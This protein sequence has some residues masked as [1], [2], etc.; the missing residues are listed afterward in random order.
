M[1]LLPRPRP[2]VHLAIMEML[3]IPVERAIVAGHRLNDEIVRLPE[4]LHHAD[5]ILVGC[6][7][8]VRHALDEPHIEA[9]TRDDVDRRKLLRLPQRIGPVSDGITEHEQPG[10]R[11]L[12][13][14]HGEPDDHGRRHAGRGLVML[15]EHDVEAE[16]I[17]EHPFVVIT[18]EQ[19]GRDLGIAFPVRQIDAQRAAVICPCIRIGLLGELVDSHARLT[20]IMTR[21]IF[22][23]SSWPGLTRASIEKALPQTMDCRGKPGNDGGWVRTDGICYHLRSMKAKSFSANS[24]GRS[25]CGK[26]PARSIRSKRAPA[27]AAQ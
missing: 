20:L 6:C 19:I 8:F 9:P 23:H 16:L 11:G 7:E 13:R 26:C 5:G 14:Q 12:P 22:L 24:S 21:A 18:V 25:R 15:I 1:R 2:D 3:A 17:G 27:M 10:T 4:S